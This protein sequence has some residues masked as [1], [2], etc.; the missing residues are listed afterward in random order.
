MKNIKLDAIDYKILDLLQSDGKLTNSAIAKIVGLS[1]SPCLRRIKALY[2]DEIIDSYRAIID[3][4]FFD[5][6]AIV[7]V[8][9][10]IEV[11]NKTE[12]NIFYEG[13]DAVTDIREIYELSSGQDYIIKIIAKNWLHYKK[14]INYKVIKI[15]FIVKIRSTGV[16]KFLKFSNGIDFSHMYDDNVQ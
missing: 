14:I 7:F 16:V 8:S 12:K 4:E 15:P 13:I 3:L 2:K 6:K 1:P 11:K 9:I 10:K 5:Y